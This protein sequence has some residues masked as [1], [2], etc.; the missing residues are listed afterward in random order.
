[1]F[2]GAVVFL[3]LAAQNVHSVFTENHSYEVVFC[4]WLIIL[5]VILWPLTMPGTPKDFK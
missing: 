1:M 4:Y 3:L 5:V 2:G